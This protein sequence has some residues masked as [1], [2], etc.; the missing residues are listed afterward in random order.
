MAALDTGPPSLFGSQCVPRLQ[1]ERANDRRDGQVARQLATEDEFNH[2]RLV[3][4]A[5]KR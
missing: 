3:S 5:T 2:I 1:I 4:E